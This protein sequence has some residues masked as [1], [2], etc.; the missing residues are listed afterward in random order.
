L[1]IKIKFFA[2]Q[3]SVSERDRHRERERNTDMRVKC[4]HQQFTV[5]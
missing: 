3:P 1:L 2:H 4:K 5:R